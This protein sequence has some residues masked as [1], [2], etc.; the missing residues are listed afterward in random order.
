MTC[1]HPKR[2]LDTHFQVELATALVWR[3]IA[4]TVCLGCGHVVERVPVET[5]P[6]SAD[7]L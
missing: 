5:V 2:W 6:V 4:V 3:E 1:R 7:F